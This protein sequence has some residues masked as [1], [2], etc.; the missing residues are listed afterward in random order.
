MEFVIAWFLLS[1]LVAII[2]DVRGHSGIGWFFLSLFLS[3]LLGLIL[4]LVLQG[5]KSGDGRKRGPCWRC[6]ELVVIGA[7]T[8]RFCGAPLEWPKP[9]KARF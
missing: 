1:L 3:P 9:A 7:T 4:A 8:C 2:A 5:K 6:R